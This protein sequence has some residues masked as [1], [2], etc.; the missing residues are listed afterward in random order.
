M[1]LIAV[2]VVV[3]PPLVPDRVDAGRTAGPPLV[4]ELSAKPPSRAGT[5]APLQQ[6]ASREETHPAA[7]RSWPHPAASREW[8]R[9]AVIA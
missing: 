7:G 3:A 2:V 4:E 6:P 1:I 9:D 8:G 5:P